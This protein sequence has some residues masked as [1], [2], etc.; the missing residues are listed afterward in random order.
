MDGK[1]FELL[2]ARRLSSAGSLT[3]QATESAKVTTSITCRTVRRD[4]F[5]NES[6]DVGDC[7]LVLRIL[8]IAQR[9]V[10]F[11][12]RRCSGSE[13]SGQCARRPLKVTSWLRRTYIL[14]RRGIRKNA[15]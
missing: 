5:S 1:A 14:K 6:T 4:E 15:I 2:N 8:I 7:T 12:R 9:R 11:W 3:P 13:R 10:L